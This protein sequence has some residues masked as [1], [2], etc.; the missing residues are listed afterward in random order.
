L[1]EETFTFAATPE[2][3]EVLL[4]GTGIIGVITRAR[5]REAPWRSLTPTTSMGGVALMSRRRQ[6]ERGAFEDGGRRPYE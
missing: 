5:S 2:R 1:V 6:R 3:A 4:F